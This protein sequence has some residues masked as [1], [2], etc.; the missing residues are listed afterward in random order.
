[1]RQACTLCLLAA[2]VSPA[3]CSELA[4]RAASG[5]GSGGSVATRRPDDPQDEGPAAEREPPRTM[6]TEP[7]ATDCTGLRTQA[8]RILEVNCA[9][10]HQDPAN[11]ANFSFCLDVDRLAMSVSSTGK[12]F[13][14]PGSPEQSRLFERVANGEMPPAVGHP[15]AHQHRR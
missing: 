10:C 1:M 6:M 8:R 11:Q 2:L 3:G 4:P 15:A 14:V 12:R 13:L 5:G 9:A 7:G